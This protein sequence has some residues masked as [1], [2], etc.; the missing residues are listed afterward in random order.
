MP[1]CDGRAHGPDAWECVATVT[2]TDT[3]GD[4]ASAWIEGIRCDSV[5]VELDCALY[6][7][8]DVDALIGALTVLRPHLEVGRQLADCDGCDICTEDDHH[9]GA[10]DDGEG[11]D[12]CCGDLSTCPTVECPRVGNVAEYLAS[13]GVSR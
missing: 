3:V 4:P 9:D 5:R 12:A 8:G 11:G 13:R 6:G 10:S 7:P 1:W 2:W